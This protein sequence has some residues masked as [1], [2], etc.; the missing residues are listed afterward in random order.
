MI[1]RRF[2][3]S[4]IVLVFIISYPNTGMVY[5]K[6]SISGNAVQL[7]P[8][9]PRLHNEIAKGSVQIPDPVEKSFLLSNSGY[10]AL[11]D[12]PKALSGTI[13]SLAVLVDFN[14]K[15]KTVNATFFDS[16]L[17]AAP[18]SGR[19]SVRDYFSEISYGQIDIVSV[20]LPSG[21]G[22]K[23]APEY[24]SYYADNNYCVNG[25]Y[26]NNCRKLAED[27]VDAVKDLVDFAD[28]DNDNDGTVDNFMIIHAGPGAEYTGK[29]YDI[30][31]HSWS[32]YHPRV[33]D[34]K[35][36]SKYVIMPEYYASFSSTS[37]DMTIGVFA[38]EMGH[39]FW[40]LKDFYDTGYDSN[41]IDDWSLMASG[42]WN[43][44]GNN[45]SSPAW[46]DAWSRI[47]MGVVSPVD[48]IG[49]FENLEI[50]DVFED[51]GVSTVFKVKTPEM[52]PLEYFLIENR[53]K[54]SGS[55]DEYLAGSG[56]LVWHV[57]DNKNGNDSQ[58]TAL[59]SCDCGS[60]HYQV[61]LVQADG[62][63]ELER[64]TD[65]ADAGDPF[66]GTS[67]KRLLN[68][69]TT[70]DIGSYFVCGDV[71]FSISN[72]SNS[73]NLMTATVDVGDTPQISIGDITT[74]EGDNGTTNAVV[75]I[76]LN[77]SSNEVVRVSYETADQDALSSID[78][79]HTSGEAVFN[80]GVTSRQV[81]IPVIGD[82][83]DEIDEQFLVN[84]SNPENGEILDS[85]GAVT[86]TDDDE[87]PYLQ[88]Q[89]ASITENV[90]LMV[91]NFDLSVASS[92]QISFSISTGDGTAKENEDYLAVVDQ[93]ISFTAGEVH[94]TM[95]IQMLDDSVPEGT[96]LFHLLFSEPQNIILNEPNMSVEILDDDIAFLN[97]LYLPML[98]R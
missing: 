98:I 61:A 70:P 59:T 63:K 14:D 1:R 58:C 91:V 74:L 12:E 3:Y 47:Q 96:E 50:K 64:Y 97:Y 21:I 20:D 67:N 34:G 54:V 32:L 19:G 2:F 87:P 86:I 18:V 66:P 25:I 48:L 39:G 33:Y 92:K 27:L 35:T 77:R 38:H 82:V 36:I 30:W 49:Y 79:E 6:D 56:L 94:K 95:N 24:L 81:S 78:F 89:Y 13:R 28:Y 26:P 15:I 65:Y 4:F 45:G 69:A 8:P 84:L 44:P 31:S 11:G 88:V 42:S 85:Q 93:L 40:N 16:L 7:M 51:N 90:G 37:S 17:F 29:T 41:G 9:H 57:D 5:V 43:G 46:P 53:Q 23:R 72:I 22:W 75:T 52:G 10:N 68:Y 55:Y 83:L 62:L 60:T 76:L 80:A 71:N 73:A